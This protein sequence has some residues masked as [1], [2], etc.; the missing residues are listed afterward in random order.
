MLCPLKEGSAELEGDGGDGGWGE[1]EVQLK[2][3]G[4]RTVLGWHVVLVEGGPWGEAG[5]RG[6][7]SGERGE[8][9]GETPEI[10]AGSCPSRSFTPSEVTVPMD[11]SPAGRTLQPPQ[12]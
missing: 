4:P 8:G 11:V 5:E 1:E 6:E 12:Q 10:L 3:V 2:S 7:G 9:R